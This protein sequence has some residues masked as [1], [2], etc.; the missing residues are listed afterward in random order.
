M[1]ISE[2]V[3]RKNDEVVFHYFGKSHTAIRI[4]DYKLIKFWN[5]K[6][7]E[8][9][10]LKDDLGELDDLSKKYPQKVQEME[11][12]LMKYIK[13][14]NAEGYIT[15]VSPKKAEKDDD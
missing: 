9:Y 7:T 11:N 8:L 4:G 6:K 15:G 5:L 10:N 2:S 13:E 14:V 3:K 12:E 1:E